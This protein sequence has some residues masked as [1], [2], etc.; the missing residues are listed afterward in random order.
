MNKCAGKYI[1]CIIK[2]PESF[3]IQLDGINGEKVHLVVSG[4]LA[5]VASDSP[6][7]DHPLTRENTTTHLKVIEEIMR[8]H[9]PV[10]PISF[11]TVTESSD[12]VKK[13]LLIPRRDEF[14]RALKDVD[15]KIELNLKAIWLDKDKIFQR[16]ILENPELQR[17]Q[18]RFSGKMVTRDVAIE[19]GRLI[20]N[21]LE[22]RKEN[23]EG[24]ILSMLKGI[25]V[26][27]KKMPLLGDQMI[28]NLA[29]LIPEN[30]QKGFDSLVKN[31]D[32]KYGA[33]KIYFKY[34]GPT[35][36]F[37]FVKLEMSLC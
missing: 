2:A 18:K 7:I 25:F 4:G 5:V 26:E 24:E 32:D 33:E 14:L 28:F 29:F 17:I 37:N 36:P 30:K 31:L 23:M 34:I 3:K 15:G 10:L 8:M 22:K 1:Y 21:E 6:V 20:A 12:A 35:P 13:R 11:G 27:Y 9:S 16:V 19:V